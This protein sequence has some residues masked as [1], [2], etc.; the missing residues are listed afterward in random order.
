MS[1]TTKIY[2]TVEGAQQIR[3]I[4]AVIRKYDRQMKARKR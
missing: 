2:E 3:R 4:R 1:E